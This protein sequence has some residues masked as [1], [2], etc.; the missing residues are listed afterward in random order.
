MKK[1]RL[2][3]H[4]NKVIFSVWFLW[5]ISLAPWLIPVIFGFSENDSPAVTVCF[6]TLVSL[7]SIYLFISALYMIQYAEIS[8]QGI[9]VYS[10]FSTIKEIKWDELIDMRTENIVTFSSAYGHRSSEDWI[11]LYTDPSQKAKEKR[12]FNRKKRGPWHP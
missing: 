7:G 9:T 2:K 6:F 3:V 1:A 8:E 10:L 12:P 11:V 4:S 5:V